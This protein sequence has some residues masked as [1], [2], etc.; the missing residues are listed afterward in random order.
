MKM[1]VMAGTKENPVEVE[2]EG[3][4]VPG[5]GDLFAVRY[6]DKDCPVGL[7]ISLEPEDESPL[8]VAFHRPTGHALGAFENRVDAVYVARQLYDAYPQ[9]WQ[10]TDVERVYAALPY[11]VGLWCYSLRKLA[12]LSLPPLVFK[13]LADFVRDFEAAI[14][15]REGP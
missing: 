1:K 14:P 3:F 5:T 9:V 15:P 10:A 13:N 12:R 11:A 7:P 2:V 4:F 6:H 8:W